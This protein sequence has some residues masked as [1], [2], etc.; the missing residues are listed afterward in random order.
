M[1]RLDKN[2]NISKQR[3]GC[4]TAWLVLMIFFNSLIAIMYFFASDIVTKKSPY[5]VSTT[6]VMLLGV[7]GVGNVIFSILLFQWKRI[8]FWG[9]IITGILTSFINLKI[10]LGTLQSL[11]GLFGIVLL[12]GILKVKK[13][14]VTGW[15]NLE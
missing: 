15:E 4:V 11:F 2:T 12:Y 5:N 6:M 1:E 14:N 3:H 9:F 13:Q 8:G 7:I 10:G